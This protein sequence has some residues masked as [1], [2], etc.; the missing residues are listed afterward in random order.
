MLEVMV[1]ILNLQHAITKNVGPPR[2]FTMM[3]NPTYYLP[4]DYASQ[5]VPTQLQLVHITISNEVLMGQKNPFVHIDQKG[6]HFTRSVPKFQ[7][8][9]MMTIMERSQ[10]VE[11]AE[12]GRDLEN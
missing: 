11:V 2:G 1:D 4:H 12:I 6:P 3:T 9:R 8:A 5:Q 7:N 10:A